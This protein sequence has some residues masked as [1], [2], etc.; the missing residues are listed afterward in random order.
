MMIKNVL[1]VTVAVVLFCLL[2]TVSFYLNAFLWNVACCNWGLPFN[3][4][5]MPGWE[6]VQIDN[7][8]TLDIPR[9]W[10]LVE[11]NGSLMITDKGGNPIFIEYN[12]KEMQLGDETVVLGE[13]TRGNILS[14]SAYISCHSTSSSNI[15]QLYQ[16]ELTNHTDDIHFILCP[17]TLDFKTLKWIANTFIYDL[18]NGSK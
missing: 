6:R 11:E 9:S 2:L 16:L 8:G 18:S 15:D 13:R 12:F 1:I 17:D 4:V 3:M 14:N 10:E 7:I 5:L